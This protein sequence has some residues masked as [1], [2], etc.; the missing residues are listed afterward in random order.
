MPHPNKRAALDILTVKR[1]GGLCDTFELE[2]PGSARKDDLIELLAHSKRASF[3]ALL[4]E[5]KRDELKEICRAHNLDD[6]GKEKEP[7]IARILGRESAPEPEQPVLP[8]LQADAGGA[9]APQAEEAKQPRAKKAAADSSANLDFERLAKPTAPA[10]PVVAEPT[11][12][13][14]SRPASVM[15]TN[16]SQLAAYIWSLADL[17]RG[18]FKQ[19]QYGRVILPFTILRRLECVLEARKPEVL[20]EVQK[21]AAMDLEPEA[22]QKFLLKAAQQAFFNTSQMDL[23]KLGSKDTKTNLLSY[24]NAFS[25]TRARSSSTSASTSS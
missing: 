25:R 12:K 5:L 14:S 13:P 22:Q 21:L 16:P 4:A 15:K 9:S 10:V 8:G 19:S 2:R 1:L 6:T 3:E 18:D 24:V 23:S 20:A 17:L 11:P 7:I